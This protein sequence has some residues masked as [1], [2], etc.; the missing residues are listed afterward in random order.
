MHGNLPGAE[1]GEDNGVEASANDRWSLVLETKN[2]GHASF[3]LFFLFCR[4]S[5]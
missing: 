1:M 3:G 2:D 4:C 5:L